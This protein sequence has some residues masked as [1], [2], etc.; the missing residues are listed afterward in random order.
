LINGWLIALPSLAQKIRRYS[1][2]IKKPLANLPGS[3]QAALWS[4]QMELYTDTNLNVELILK[5]QIEL[6][7]EQMITADNPLRRRQYE[8]LMRTAKLTLLELQG[9]A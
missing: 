8:K 7:Y 9:N 3:V 2:Q 1:N 5:S 6:A 4:I